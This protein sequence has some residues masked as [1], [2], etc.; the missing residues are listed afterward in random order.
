MTSKED[1]VK[2]VVMQTN[3]TDEEAEEKLKKHDYNYV[4]VIKLY[5]NPD[6]ETKKKAPEKNRSTNEKMMDEIRNF[7]DTANRQY[8][9]RKEQK[10]RND[11]IQKQIYEKFL[12]QKKIHTS[13]VY[14]P[15]TQLSCSKFCPNP[16][17]P[18]LLGKDRKY[19]KEDPT[20]K[21]EPIIEE[22]DSIE[23]V[24]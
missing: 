18:G 23:E 1:M 22:V 3:Y 4:K 8:I 21:L 13:C 7:M 9:Q 15:P 10:E 5:L 2:F 14:N 6:L 11:A 19:I 16:M 17:C 12:E 20:K 24:E